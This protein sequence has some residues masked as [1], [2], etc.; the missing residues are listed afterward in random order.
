MIVRMPD[1]R[2]LIVDAKTPMDAYLSAMEAKEADQRQQFLVQHARN[3][4]KRVDELSRKAYWSQFKNSP[5]YVILFIPG[6]QFLTAA[7][8]QDS[9]L[10]EDALQ[11][12]VV[13]STPTTI[14]ALLRAV[15][16]GWRQVTVAENAEKI[17]KLGEELYKRV[18]TFTEH[19]DKVGKNL[20]GSVDAYNRAIGSLGRQVMPSIRKFKE[21]GIQSKKQPE[22]PNLLHRFPGLQGI[23][24]T[25]MISPWMFV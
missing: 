3:M 12:R 15:A 11:N 6:E 13:L 1:Q 9:R 20:H 19:L 7:P 18:A 8:E 22:E 16:F 2:E 10:L 25:R 4:R 5:D 21:L 24:S 23:W 14:I 17:Q